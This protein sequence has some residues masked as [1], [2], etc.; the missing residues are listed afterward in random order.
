MPAVPEQQ[1]DAPLPHEVMEFLNGFVSS[2]MNRDATN[3]R[4]LYEVDFNNLTETFYSANRWP[5]PAAVDRIMQFS[6][7]SYMLLLC[8]YK[9]LYYRHLYSKC[10]SQVD[11]QDRIDSWEN[12]ELLTGYFFREECQIM[13]DNRQGLQLPSEWVWDILDEYVYQFWEAQNWRMRNGY[14]SIKTAEMAAE[15]APE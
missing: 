1:H 3:L 8:L 12:Y 2:A 6:E 13:G 15:I 9:E 14:E 7:Q 4:R 5:T 10:A 11:H